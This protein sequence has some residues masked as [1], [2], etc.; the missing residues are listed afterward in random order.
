MTPTLLPKLAPRLPVAAPRFTHVA[1]PADGLLFAGYPVIRGAALTA[2]RFASLVPADQERVL[3]TLAA[4]LQAVHAFPVEEARAIGVKEPPSRESAITSMPPEEIRVFPLLAPEEGAALARLIESFLADE[5]NLTYPPTL[6]YN[7]FATEH[8]RFDT[9][10][11]R[12]SGI[13]DWGDLEIGD[14]D[15]DLMYLRQ[16]YGEDFVRRLLAYYPHPEPDRLLH[17]LRVWDACD[18]FESVAYPPAEPH[19]WGTD[20]EMLAAVRAILRLTILR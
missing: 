9:E 4:F 20:D 1:R 2:E 8:I 11:N 10:A 18:L 19:N 17:K 16:D 12:I 7:D 5:R 13:I 15:Y 14:P 6:L 3:G